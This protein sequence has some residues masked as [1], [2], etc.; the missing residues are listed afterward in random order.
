MGKGKGVA[1]K[2]PRLLVAHD[3]AVQAR[4]PLAPDHV[5]HL[6]NVLRRRDGDAV[7]V[8]NGRDGEFLATLTFASKSHAQ[9]FLTDQLRTQATPTFSAPSL[10]FAPLKSKERMRFLY[11][12]AVE[13]GVGELQP[14]TT[15]RTEASKAINV[16]RVE[17]QLV[18][19][20]E[21]C[22]RLS[23]V[24]MHEMRALCDVLSLGEQT[25]VVFAAIERDPGAS[26]I[27]SAVQQHLTRE[28]GGPRD[29]VQGCGFLIGPEGGF[30]Q[31]VLL[32]SFDT[33]IHSAI[34]PTL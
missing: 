33:F 6:R 5:H 4:V 7:R 16:E 8:F 14:V 26:P 28:Q 13:L 32:P 21:Q 23:L 15:A 31:E 20:T 12:K 29:A 11:E 18:D 1:T 30:T 24:T 22:E 10:C 17:K 19:A 3:L 34:N 25:G 27:A 2:T 9:A